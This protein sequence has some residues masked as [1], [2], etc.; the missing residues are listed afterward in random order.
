MYEIYT[1][2]AKEFH[3]L[4]VHSDQPDSERMQAIE[5]IRARRCK[6]IVC[7]DM[8]GEGFD[9]P[10]LKIAALHDIH[11]SLAV[12]I[13]FVGRFTRSAMGIG[14]ATI[15][16]NAG[17]A[18]VEE[19]IED[20]YIKDSDWN[21]VLRRLSEGGTS[22][23]QQRSFF[24]NGFE[25]PPQAVPLQNIHPKMSTVT[26]QTACRDW[27]P[28]AIWGLFKGVDLLIEP[29]INP[30][31]HVMLFI[32]REK[33]PVVWGE[34]KIVND[35]VHHLY[36][37]YWDE[38]QKLL[39]INSTNNKSLHAALA[40]KIAGDNVVLLDGEHTYRALD[41]VKRLIL[42][43][44]GLLHT[45]NRASQF[46]M[47]VGSD[48]KAGLSQASIQNRRKSNLFGR[49]YEHGERVTI[50]ISYKG[51]VWSHW[52]AE[53]I[54]AWVNWCKNIGQK[55][56][57][58]TISTDKILEQAIIPV[59]IHQRPTLVPLT[60][61]WP[62]Y[63]YERSDEAITVEMGGQRTPFYD[64]DL[65]I[66][67]FAAQGPIQ[68]CLSINGEQAEYEVVFTRN[69][70]EYRPICEKEAFLTVSGR[71]VPLT[72][73]FQEYSPIITFEDTSVLEN[74]EIFRP[75]TVRKPYDP[76]TIDCWAWTGVDLTAESQYKRRK[77]P[78]RL[79][80]QADSIQAYVLGQLVSGCGIDYDIIF[81]DDGSGEVADIVALSS[82]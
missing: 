30:T 68:F 10:Q 28:N 6:V 50:G 4:I 14:A 43:N 69:T 46:T 77:N 7:V 35:V 15:I 5:A 33:A 3:P 38:H 74:C 48:I 56:L 37:F 51:R 29:T 17:D 40:K 64:V 52:I 78:T 26:Y 80:L 41:G 9:L 1:S 20:L 72:E 27:D 2:L 71:R 65:R 73:W 47:H 49:G 57:D 19:A 45:L 31:E 8:L 23:H 36:L 60:I 58:E 34:T 32:T 16:A 24:I 70:I 13:Q 53:D 22:R 21:I 62:P 25:Y 81:D 82:R 18:E 75:K 12:T 76:F 39:F 42:T 61:D 67:T 79:D 54:S 11:K 44:L 55:L 63:F 66:L 59:E